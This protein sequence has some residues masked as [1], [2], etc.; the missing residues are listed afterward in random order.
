MSGIAG[1]V[2]AGGAAPDEALLRRMAARLHTGAPDGTRLRILDGCGL[3]HALLLAGDEASPP[4]QPFSLGHHVWITADARLDA[5]AELARAL[6]AAGEPAAAD[7]S[8]AELILRAF[9]AWGDACVE[10]LLGDFAFAVWDAPRR[11]LFCARDHLGVK[12]FYHASPADGFVFSS[13]VSS[14]LLH[15]RVGREL[16]EL[17]VA[18]FLVHAYQQDLERTIHRQVRMLPPGH[19]LA[20]EDGRVRLWRWWSLPIEEPLRYRRTR[21]YVDHFLDVFSAAVRERTPPGPAGIFMSGGRDS[22][23]VAAL[24]RR[25]VPAADLRSFTAYHERLIPDQERRYAAVAGRALGIPIT[26]TAVDDYRLFQ[27]YGD[28]PRLERPE[29]VDA[30]L[31]AIEVDQWEQ[32]AAHSRVL[33]TGFGGDAVLRETRARLARL[34]LGGHLLRAAWEAGEYAWLHRRIPR[35][36]ARTWLRTR[37]ARQRSAAEAPPWLD[38]EFARRVDAAGR[39][40]E[41]NA[42]LPAEHPTRPEAYDQLTGPLWP[43]LFAYSDP[44]FTGVPV[45]Q[46]HPFFDVRLVR[47]LLSV[48]PAQWYNDKG[49]LRIGMRG[50][51]P[52]EVLRRPKSPLP[53]DPLRARRERDGDGWLGGRT[54]GAE[55]GPYVDPT[56]VPRAAGGRGPE[57]G[58]P[59]WMQLRPLALSLWLRGQGS[60]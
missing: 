38:A 10:H 13:S 12:P 31:L 40:A 21:D 51:L 20:V 9:R 54:L 18:D 35:P 6:S 3:A 14:V 37:D 32:A 48:P 29:P 4:A 53:G 50:L 42:R 17:A 11:R 25:Q 47:F 49:L 16:D 26:W 46:R 56:R 28:D 39:V 55:V 5:R 59:L 27:G 60:R 45:E 58:E 43:Y 57:D 52:E 23:A 36:G 15:P 24:A 8:A 30:A 1:L 7:A 41:Q 19:A 44:G 34:A 2:P 33:L 22:T